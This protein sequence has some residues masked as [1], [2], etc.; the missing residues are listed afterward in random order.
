MVWGSKR[1][2]NVKKQEN[3]VESLDQ[4]TVLRHRVNLRA[5]S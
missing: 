1:G 5:D 2:E 4:M 3:A